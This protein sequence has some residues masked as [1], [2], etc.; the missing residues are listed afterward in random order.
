[1]KFKFFL[2]ALLFLCLGIQLPAISQKSHTDDT[3]MVQAMI[4][5]AAPHAVVDGGNKLYN[6]SSLYLKSN[7]TLKNFRFIE[8]PSDKNFNAVLNI[9]GKTSIPSDSQ[10]LIK[11]PSNIIL[12][13]IIVDGNRISQ[14]QINTQKE[15]GG[16]HGIRIIGK[17]ANIQILNCKINNCATD[18]ICFFSLSGHSGSQ[19]DLPFKN[20]LIKNTICDSNRRHGMSMDGV[21]GLKIINCYFNN[22]GLNLPGVE[23]TEAN[24]TEGKTGASVSYGKGLLVNYGNGIDF[25]GYGPGSRV[26][27]IQI[28]GSQFLANA[29]QGILFLDKALGK[30]FL[31]RDYIEISGCS[32]DYGLAK[33][34]NEKAALSFVGSGS[35]YVYSNISLQNNSFDG[36]VILR[37]TSKAQC[38]ENTYVTPP[39]SKYAVILVNSSNIE[40]K[41]KNTN[42]I[43]KKIYTH[44]SNYNVIK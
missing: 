42:K 16:R 6:V 26:T 7:M 44:L 39:N 13:N 23:L 15:D 14:T 25:E 12:E 41:G 24:K 22:N 43:S 38:L 18:G 8:L 31:P 10:F 28:S 1:M 36:Y 20:I 35:G 3:R 9:I 37:F 11:D 5:K 27:H 21:D 17:A 33:K 30:N 29:R 4:D 2:V 32:L 19:T 40:F 34:K